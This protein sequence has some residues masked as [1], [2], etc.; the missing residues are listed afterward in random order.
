MTKFKSLKERLQSSRTNIIEQ[1]AKCKNVERAIVL[2]DEKEMIIDGCKIFV[3]PETQWRLNAYC[4]KSTVRKED[5]EEE[6]KKKA[7]S[8]RR[9]KRRN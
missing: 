3:S 1:C 2:M 8:I 9:P 4:G 5:L 6:A 7:Q